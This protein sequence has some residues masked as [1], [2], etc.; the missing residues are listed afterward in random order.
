MVAVATQAYA[1][2]TAKAGREGMARLLIAFTVARN[3]DEE[4][5]RVAVEALARSRT[6][7]FE[8]ENPDLFPERKRKKKRRER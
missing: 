6:S 4:A 1:E 3:G 5:A 7:R 2:R 8:T